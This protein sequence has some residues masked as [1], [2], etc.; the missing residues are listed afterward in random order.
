MRMIYEELIHFQASFYLCQNILI[1]FHLIILK[2]IRSN[3]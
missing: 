2:Y 1:S 3:K